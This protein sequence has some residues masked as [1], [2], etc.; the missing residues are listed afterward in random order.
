MGDVNKQKTKILTKLKMQLYR[1]YIHIFK[2]NY[3]YRS[4]RSKITI[5]MSLK[6]VWLNG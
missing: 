4:K 2:L 1:K 3:Y 5:Q 6:L